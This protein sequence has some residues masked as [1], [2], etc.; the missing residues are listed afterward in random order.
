[1][2]RLVVGLLL[3]GC[4][5]T[6]QQPARAIDWSQCCRYGNPGCCMAWYIQ[7]WWEG[8]IPFPGVPA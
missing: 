8:S 4:S 5:V 3:L 1:M 6:F 7:L 2:K